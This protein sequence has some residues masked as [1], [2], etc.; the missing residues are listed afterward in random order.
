MQQEGILLDKYITSL[1]P[2]E[3]KVSPK[4]QKVTKV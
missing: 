4:Q 2:K 1:Q 3:A